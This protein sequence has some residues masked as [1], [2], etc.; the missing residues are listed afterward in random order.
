MSV[1]ERDC[2]V[3]NQRTLPLAGS[4]NDYHGAIGRSNVDSYRD[5]WS[6]SICALKCKAVVT[7]A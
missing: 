3:V 5:L 4:A 6:G 2:A 7:S 1:S